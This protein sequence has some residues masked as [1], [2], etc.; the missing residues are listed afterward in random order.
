MTTQACPKV[1]RSYTKI[2]R[3]P[4]CG[5]PITD[6]NVGGYRSYCLKCVTAMPPLPRE[7]GAYNIAGQ[8]PDFRWERGERNFALSAP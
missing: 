6:S 4:G 8:Y 5:I 7:P 3:C 2:M 1:E